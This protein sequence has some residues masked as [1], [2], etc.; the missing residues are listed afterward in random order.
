MGREFELKYQAKAGDLEKIREKF[1]D[2]KSISMETTYYDT[3]LLALR[4]RRWTLRR[5][6]ENGLSVC[7][8][9]TPLPDGSRGEW[10]VE[11]PDISEGLPKLTPWRRRGTVPDCPGRCGS[12]LRRPV[13]KACQASSHPGRHRGAGSGQKACS[14]AAVRNCPLPRWRWS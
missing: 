4:S 7:T 12:L 1:G 14:W 5:R 2:F 11:A 8:V 9:K 10:E 6:L 3:P 13:R